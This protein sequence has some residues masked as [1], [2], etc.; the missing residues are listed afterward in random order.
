MQQIAFFAEQTASM[1]LDIEGGYHLWFFGQ[2]P[3][4]RFTRL[5]DAEL[6]KI[7]YCFCSSQK[8]I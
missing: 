7:A 4:H 3:C 6:S 5:N 2:A 1:F 8:R